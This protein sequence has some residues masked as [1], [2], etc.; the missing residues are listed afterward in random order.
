MWILFDNQDKTGSL[1]ALSL[2][3]VRGDKLFL[4]LER[5]HAELHG[6]PVEYIVWSFLVWGIKKN[7]LKLKIVGLE[8]RDNSVM[9]YHC[10][11]QIWKW[12]FWLNIL[13]LLSAVFCVKK[14]KVQSSTTFFA[15]LQKLCKNNKLH[16]CGLILLLKRVKIC[17]IAHSLKNVHMYCLKWMP[18]FSESFPL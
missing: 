17:A 8:A 9:C 12:F 10:L 6:P 7:V 16:N 3:L 11:L 14:Y 1:V 2:T 13:Y 4:R 18:D 15:L 5:V